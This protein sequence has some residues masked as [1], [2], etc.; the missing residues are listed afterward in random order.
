MQN[1]PNIN[2]SSIGMSPVTLHPP[3]SVSQCDTQAPASHSHL[4]TPSHIARGLENKIKFWLILLTCPVNT[5]ISPCHKGSFETFLLA[6]SKER[7]I[8]SKGGIHR[9]ASSSQTLLARPQLLKS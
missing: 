7:G 9:L 3:F 1:K 8:H 6:R 2:I 5:A 4:N